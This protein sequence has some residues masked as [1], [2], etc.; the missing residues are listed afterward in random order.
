VSLRVF[1]QLRESDHV[2][3]TLLFSDEQ[4]GLHPELALAKHRSKQRGQ[5]FLLA[6]VAAID[7]PN[8]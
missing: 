3:I 4:G 6:K 8:A 7:E 2:Q 1:G 5:T